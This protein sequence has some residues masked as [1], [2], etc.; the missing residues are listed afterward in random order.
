MLEAQKKEIKFVPWANK[1]EEF[2][3][4]KETPFFSMVVPTVDTYRN[5]WC[6][7]ILLDK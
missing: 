5:A 6:L 7:D 3:F 4:D 1:I 2:V